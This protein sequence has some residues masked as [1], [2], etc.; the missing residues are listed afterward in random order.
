[1]VS[2]SCFV[3]LS[4]VLCNSFLIKTLHPDGLGYYD[5]GEERLGDETQRQQQSKKSGTTHL[6]AAALK[7][8][9]RNKKLLEEKS[10]SLKNEAATD[11]SSNKSM[12]DFVQRGAVQQRSSTK[13]S[14]SSSKKRFAKS[15]PSVDLDSLLDTLDTP[16]PSTAKKHRRMPTKKPRPSRPKPARRAGR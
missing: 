12:W 1:M 6:T 10:A 16:T 13:A 14:S 4:F 5:D 15:A 8:A 2:S 9:R 3:S 11:N 7:K